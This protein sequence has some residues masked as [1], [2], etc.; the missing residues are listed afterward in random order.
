[1]LINPSI[2][3]EERIDTLLK[4]PKWITT[5]SHELLLVVRLSS[6]VTRGDG[7]GTVIR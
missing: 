1:M 2:Q 3:G 7:H 6:H 5:P 4:Q